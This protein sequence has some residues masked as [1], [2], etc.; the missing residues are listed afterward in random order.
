MTRSRAF[1]GLGRGGA[2]VLSTLAFGL[3]FVTL[4]AL[5]R[6]AGALYR[7]SLTPATESA[8]LQLVTA[9]EI[10]E[11]VLLDA[12][13]LA[14]EVCRD[15]SAAQVYAGQLLAFYRA[16]EGKDAVL[17]FSPGGWGT[18]SVEHSRGWSSIVQGL[19]GILRPRGVKWQVLNYRRTPHKWYAKID[20]ACAQVRKYPH[21][22]PHL[23]RQLDFV[24]A[25]H[26]G[27]TVFLASESNGTMF[28]DRVMLEV[29]H[30]ERVYNVATGP[31]FYYGMRHL[32]H[33]LILND[34]G[35]VPDAFSQGHFGT[36]LRSNFTAVFGL[37]GQDRPR[38]DVMSIIRAPGHYYGWDR[39]KVAADISGF[40]T[41][42]LTP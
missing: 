27:L 41:G 37:D 24:T 31:P 12:Q 39:P 8:P 28:N 22:A 16:V 1:A 33:T 34:N 7:V 2:A 25:H 35:E 38:G 15:D 5:A 3:I 18:K 30:R 40:V 21:K 9:G 32:E 20:E 6:P 26:P 11:A 42:I 29:K 19:D 14:R 4:V 10:P 36:M 13:Q 23:A 17:I